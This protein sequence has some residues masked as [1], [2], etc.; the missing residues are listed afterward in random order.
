MFEHDG[1]C[2]WSF[3]VQFESC[4]TNPDAWATGEDVPITDGAFSFTSSFREINGTFDG[5][6]ASGDVTIGS[7]NGSWMATPD[8]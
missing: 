1:A 2:G 7:C 4:S 6:M 8:P 5:D 3:A